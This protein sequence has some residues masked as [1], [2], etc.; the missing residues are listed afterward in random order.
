MIK[1][2]RPLKVEVFALEDEDFLAK[3]GWKSPEPAPYEGMHGVSIPHG[4]YQGKKP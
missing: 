4:E 2:C 3:R 1:C